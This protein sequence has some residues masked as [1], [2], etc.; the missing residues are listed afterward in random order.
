M[1]RCRATWD[2]GR[3]QIFALVMIASLTEGS[4]A[5]R[6]DALARAGGVLWRAGPEMVER[7]TDSGLTWTR[8]ARLPASDEPAD[9]AEDDPE[10]APVRQL[11]VLGD[12]V[13]MVGEAGLLALQ[14]G[15]LSTL[16]RAPCRAL[17]VGGTG[18]VAALCGRRLLTSGDGGASFQGQPA[19]PGARAIAWRGGDLVTAPTDGLA[20]TT[21]AGLV[22]CET[23]GLV[24]EQGRVRLREPCRDVRAEGAH[25]VAWGDDAAWLSTDGG[26]E[27][28]PL[29]AAAAYDVIDM[30]P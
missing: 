4:H 25:V 9:E 20:V 22:R 7:S 8:A 10:R 26:I 15:Q 30:I 11:A 3:A 19:P 2:D 21:R 18:R 17:A 27:F 5:A 28:A 13:L 6:A 14:S 23:R 16:V 12:T 29:P 24:D 1:T